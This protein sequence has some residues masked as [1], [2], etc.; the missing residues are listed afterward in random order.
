MP[1]RSPN[2]LA[3]DIG[4]T[5]LAMAIFAPDRRILVREALR[6]D[7]Q[8]G[9]EW[10]LDQILTLARAWQQ[11]HGFAR[12]GVGF[13]GPVDFPNQ[14]IA[15]SMHVGGWID[16][17][18]TSFLQEQLKVPVLMDNDGN[19]GALGEYRCSPSPSPDKSGRPGEGRGEGAP[20]RGLHPSPSS[21]FYMT[22]S[23]GIGG[24]LVIDGKVHRG[25]DSMAGEIGHTPV[26]PD[27]PECLCG[28]RG[29]L[30]RL[31]SGLWL[32][33]DHGQSAEELFRDPAFVSR[34][35]VDLAAGL[36]I[37]TMLLN[38]ARIVVGGGIARAGDALFI[39]L[40]QELSRQLPPTYN[41]HADVVPAALGGDSVLYGA[42]CLAEELILNPEP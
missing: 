6:T 21:L 27:G 4:G 17:P 29:C 37:I 26:R 20:G 14:R 3:I 12:C 13:G 33:R 5:K 10:M 9:R 31:C 39:P 36:K 23:T 22:I 11:L 25:I 30:E 28:S 38:P 16:F 2:S 7:S 1:G 19:A 8:G 41:L 24:G 32:Q 34:Y 35:V 18:L 42:L 40:R 15:R